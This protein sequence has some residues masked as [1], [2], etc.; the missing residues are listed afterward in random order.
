MSLIEVAFVR[1]VLKCHC[2]IAT[3][4]QRPLAVQP[5]VASASDRNCSVVT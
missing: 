1:Y 4:Q 3:R 2:F 5:R